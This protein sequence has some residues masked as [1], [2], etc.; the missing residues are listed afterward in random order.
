MVMKEEKDNGKV[1]LDLSGLKTILTKHSSE[2][3]TVE[4]YRNDASMKIENMPE[5]ANVFDL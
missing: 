2:I 5:K 4:I 3:G 1:V